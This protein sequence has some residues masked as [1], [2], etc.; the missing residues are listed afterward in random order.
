MSPFKTL[1]ETL[2]APALA[3]YDDLATLFDKRDE[4]WTKVNAQTR[5]HECDALL[6][7][8]LAAD[9]WCAE[10]KDI[11][12]AAEDPQVVHMGMIT[13]YEH[14]TVGTVR[15]VAPAI[16][17]SETPPRIDRPAPLIG[18][19]GREILKEFGLSAEAIAALEASGDMTVAEA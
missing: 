9:I 17:M 15:V 10:V 2:A 18:Q 19:H 11:R 1:Y 14:P 4:V 12:R 7:S 13:S 8:M 3:V 6:A 16:R 5:R